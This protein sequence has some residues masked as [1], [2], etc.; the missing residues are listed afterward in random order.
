MRKDTRREK[1]GHWKGGRYIKDSGYVMVY[2]PEH[3]RANSNG[4]VCEHISI[5]EK[6]L[7]KRLPDGVQIHHYGKKDD[8]TKIVIC[9]NQ[10][11][12]YLLHVRQKA[13]AACGYPNKLKCKFCGEYD[14]P[15][16][17]YVGHS[18]KYGWTCYHRSCARFYDNARYAKNK[19]GR[20]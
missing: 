5:A 15:K 18:N 1:N 17:M 19:R 12:H 7:G 3:G 11:Y 6:V 8:N 4:Y 20:K 9:E 10:E 14:F 13:L 2:N 16:N